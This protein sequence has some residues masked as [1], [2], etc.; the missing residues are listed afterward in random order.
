MAGVERVKCVEYKTALFSL[1]SDSLLLFARAESTRIIRHHYLQ[2][3]EALM[4][5]V[6][7]SEPHTTL[8]YL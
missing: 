2:Q 8:I 6:S 1:F 3:T 4:C 7:L 5:R